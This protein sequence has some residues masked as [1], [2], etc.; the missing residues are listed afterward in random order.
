MAQVCSPEVAIAVKETPAGMVTGTGLL[1]DVQAGSTPFPRKP[2]LPQQYALPVV[3]SAQL[4]ANIPAVIA[5]NLIPV[6]MITALGALLF[7]VVPFPSSPYPLSPQ[8]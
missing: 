4:R 8:Q 3:V 7:T 1:L 6:G 2:F 5:E